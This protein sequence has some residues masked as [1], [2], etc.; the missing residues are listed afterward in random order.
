[1][2]SSHQYLDDEHQSSIMMNFHD[3]TSSNMT[4]SYFAEDGTA[5]SPVKYCDSNRRVSIPME[6]RHEMRKSRSLLVELEIQSPSNS[7]SSCNTSGSNTSSATTTTAT[8]GNG[9]HDSKTLLSPEQKTH[10]LLT[11]PI[12]RRGTLTFAT[13]LSELK[14]AGS[15]R[16]RITHRSVS[17]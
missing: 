5:S 11:S 1:M 16:D 9:H 6:R 3:S 10:Q 7:S 8:M 13:S 12:R 2:S 4:S 14:R 15:S 17:S